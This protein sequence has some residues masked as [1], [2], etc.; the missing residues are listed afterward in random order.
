MSAIQK[1]YRHFDVTLQAITPLHIGTGNVLMKGID[2]IDDGKTTWRLDVDRILADLWAPEF[3]NAH[4]A[5][6]LESI[7]QAER[8]QY[9]I[10]SAKGAIRA[11]QTSSKLRECIKT[12][13]YQ[14]Y[15]P[16]SSLKGALR[17]ALAW[18]GWPE[19]VKAVQAND[20][21]KSKSWAG[22]TLEDRLFRPKRSDK[23]GPNKDLLRALHIGD[24]HLQ[25]EGAVWQI[26]NI[27]VAKSSSFDS[28]IEVEAIGADTVFAG[29]LTIDDHLFQPQTDSVLGLHSLEPWIVTEL[30]QRV[31]QHT[32]DLL[33]RRIARS[34][35]MQQNGAANVRR[36]FTD[37]RGYVTGLPANK[38]VICL[39]WGGGWDSKTF[40][41]R[42]Q[43]N[44]AFFEKE[45]IDRFK[46]HRGK[47]A[48]KAGDPFPRTQRL[49]VRQR[50]NATTIRGA[51]GW[52]LLTLVPH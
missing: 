36:F 32:L 16:G 35:R 2:F 13:D 27:Q 43:G 39:G 52:C 42:L 31:N 11:Q 41:S 3:G 6:L 24:L 34:S 20:I 14:P 12:P 38:C 8:D 33:D 50:D 44:P 21:R 47:V 15:I 30:A 37:L 18:A 46:L 28:P 25:T 1:I 22:Q 23:D 19:Q 5:E 10:Y 17:T 40:G 29:R 49:I 51:L 7:P 48:R 26:L 45:I 9:V 4:P